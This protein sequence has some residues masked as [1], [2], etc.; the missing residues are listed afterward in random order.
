MVGTGRSLSPILFFW[1]VQLMEA[2]ML[3]MILYILILWWFKLLS[4]LVIF[5]I[6]LVWLADW[7]VWTFGEEDVDVNHTRRM[8]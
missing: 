6:L 8:R 2:Y 3:H 5:S 4:A 1:G 7:L